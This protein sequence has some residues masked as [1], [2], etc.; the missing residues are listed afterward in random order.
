MPAPAAQQR[1]QGASEAA[2]RS[3]P[4]ATTSSQ[5]Q[6][7]LA[8]LSPGDRPSVAWDDVVGLEKAKRAL[9]EAVVLPTLRADIFRGIRA[10]TRGILLFGPPGTG[11][12]LLAKAAAAAS[13]A[14][15][16]PVSA[17]SLTSKWHGEGER[18]VLELFEAARAAAP[19]IVF[20]DEVDSLLGA[21]GQGE[22]EASRRLKTEFLVRLDG[23]T[24]GAGEERVLVLAATNR[25]GDLDEAVV[26][27][28]PLRIYVP[29]PD[30]A[31][32]RLMLNSLLKGVQCC[33]NG[34]RS[35]LVSFDNV[36]LVLGCV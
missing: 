18:H 10:P 31:A 16:F 19:S 34:A 24:T 14:A 1:W 4:A 17:S 30:A 21:R 9:H 15:F 11:K 13:G 23:V 32:R 3:R 29:L 20:V 12:T 36:L 26:R 5:P 7:V 27:R 25:P 35:Q 6:K 28:L 22:H 33:L 2:L 8:P